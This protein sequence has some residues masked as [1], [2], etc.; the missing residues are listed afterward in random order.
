MLIKKK[1]ITIAI[2]FSILYSIR[3]VVEI[4]II[5]DNS[6]LNTVQQMFRS[7]YV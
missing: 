1:K 7:L 5:I 2:M 3:R 6:I 4:Y